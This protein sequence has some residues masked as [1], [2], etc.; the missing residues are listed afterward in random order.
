MIKKCHPM[1]SNDGFIKKFI[2]HTIIEALQEKDLEKPLN[3][4]APRPPCERDYGYDIETTWQV[5]GSNEKWI[6]KSVKAE[7]V[8]LNEH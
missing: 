6:L 2:K 4:T 8:K 7:W 3:I 5:K 1:K